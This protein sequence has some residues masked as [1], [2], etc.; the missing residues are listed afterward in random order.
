RRHTR[1]SRDWSSDVCSSDLQ[2]FLLKS[3]QI[4]VYLTSSFAALK[5]IFPQGHDHKICCLSGLDGFFKS[6]PVGGIQFKVLQETAFSHS[7]S[8]ERRVG[9]G[10]CKREAVVY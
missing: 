2:K 3:E 10:G 8:E 4:D 6:G 7:R 1:F 5:S 9:K